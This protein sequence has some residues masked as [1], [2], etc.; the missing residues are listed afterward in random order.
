MR[1]ATDNAAGRI[2][3]RFPRQTDV[4]LLELVAAIGDVTDDE[5]ELLATVHYM[6]ESGTVRLCG[7]FR[8]IDPKLLR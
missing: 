1:R 8:N 4:T 5:E 7:N 6:L 3:D 2:Q